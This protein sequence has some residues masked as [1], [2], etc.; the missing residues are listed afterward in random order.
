[1]KMDMPGSL[2]EGLY[3]VFKVV[4]NMICAQLVMLATTLHCNVF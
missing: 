3:I 1:M 2:V 4:A